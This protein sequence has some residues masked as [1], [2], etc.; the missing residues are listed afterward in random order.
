M[1]EQLTVFIT[2]L[3]HNTQQL[4]GGFDWVQGDESGLG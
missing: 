3:E 1:K 4:F 2:R